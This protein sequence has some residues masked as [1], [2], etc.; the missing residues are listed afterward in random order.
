[1]IG[2]MDILKRVSR[3][4]TEV[5]PTLRKDAA[6]V[7]VTGRR[8]SMVV[9]ERTHTQI[10]TH[11]RVH[12]RESMDERI[13]VFIIFALFELQKCHRATSP[14]ADTTPKASLVGVTGGKDVDL[15]WGVAG[16]DFLKN[17]GSLLSKPLLPE[18]ELEPESGTL[19]L[20][21]GEGVDG[22]A[23]GGLLCLRRPPVGSS[24]SMTTRSIL[25]APEH[26]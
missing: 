3:T 17:D 22:I 21:A 14:P 19:F 2:C 23:W 10:H 18:L 9:R 24:P 26:V 4:L 25:T 6:L 13:H 15:P 7:P 1:M 8:R 11:A 12:A 5:G 20:P 16:D